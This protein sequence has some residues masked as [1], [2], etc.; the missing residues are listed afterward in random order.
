MRQAVLAVATWRHIFIGLA[1][2]GL[3]LGLWGGLRL[4][5]TLDQAA[6][7]PLS[8][9][10]VGAAAAEVL[11]TRASIGNSLAATLAFGALFAFITSFDEVVVVL[12]IGNYTDEGFA[13][14]TAAIPTA[15]RGFRWGLERPALLSYRGRW[16]SSP[17]RW[18][19]RR[20]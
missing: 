9:A 7:R 13:H 20:R 6:R 4:P 18:A 14:M 3:I 17:S 10:N 16:G 11:T 12:F 5:E 1:A 2:Y 19:Q 15:L 8:A